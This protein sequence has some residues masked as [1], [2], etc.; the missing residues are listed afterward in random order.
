VCS[1]A[2]VCLSLLPAPLFLQRAA[3]SSSHRLLST[4]QALFYRLHTHT[5]LSTQYSVHLRCSCS[6][7]C[8]YSCSY[9]YFCSYPPRPLVPVAAGVCR[10]K[11]C[12]PFSKTPPLSFL[13]HT[14]CCAS[15]C[16]AQTTVEP[17]PQS[18]SRQLLSAFFHKDLSNG[19][20]PYPCYP[21]PQHRPTASS[22][23]DTVEA[24][25]F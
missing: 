5:V 16:Q 20:N 6:C 4:Y 19:R 1:T 14:P 13:P 10:C 23:C 11:S 24:T 2:L 18:S 7:S 21:H 17:R 25:T 8:S 9:S 15:H 3:R 22:T 12:A